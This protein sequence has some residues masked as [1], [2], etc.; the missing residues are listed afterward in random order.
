MAP[1]STRL[2]K[3]GCSNHRGV[4]VLGSSSATVTATYETTKLP[5]PF[6]L[7][8]LMRWYEWKRRALGTPPCLSIGLPECAFLPDRT[9]QFV[10][11]KVRAPT[12]Q[13]NPL[14]NPNTVESYRAST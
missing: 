6:G 1:T 7:G 2:P 12:A 8:V 10:A 4:C 14:P 3:V 13:K 5:G 9:C 11:R